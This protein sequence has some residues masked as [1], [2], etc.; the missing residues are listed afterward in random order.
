MN[1]GKNDYIQSDLDVPDDYFTKGRSWRGCNLEV[2][3]DINIDF[4]AI[5]KQTNLTLNESIRKYIELALAEYVCSVR[6]LS[7]PLSSER[8][9]VLKAVE[10]ACKLLESF[11]EWDGPGKLSES[12][13]DPVKLYL[14][15]FVTPHVSCFIYERDGLPGLIVKEMGERGKVRFSGKNVS[16]YLALCR[17]KIEK[18]R[19]WPVQAG[20][21]R[22]IEIWRCL[23][24]LRNCYKSAGGEGR[25]VRRS[26]DGSFSGPFLT[27]LK[28]LFDHLQ[29]PLGLA[30]SPFSETALGALVVNKYR[31]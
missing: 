21:P 5:E 13:Y 23:R 4:D 26:A 31:I 10:D 9:K 18:E 19:S 7:K 28:L 2:L 11:L 14:Y 3:S 30:E 17:K 6:T 24:S 25:G 22:N 8:N 29:K 1:I 16:D 12:E 15:E 20:R 27:F